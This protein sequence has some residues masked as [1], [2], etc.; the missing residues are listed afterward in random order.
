MSGR[1]AAP[2]VRAG[3]REDRKKKAE[4]TEEQLKRMKAMEEK[5][6]KWNKGYKSIMS[7]IEFL[8]RYSD[9]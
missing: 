8:M 9:F 4:P 5:Y 7:N 6:Q 3:G 1:H 2:V